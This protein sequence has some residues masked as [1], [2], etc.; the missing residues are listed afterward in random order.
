LRRLKALYMNIQELIKYKYQ[1]YLSLFIKFIK[2]KLMK[3]NTKIRLALKINYLI[4]I[5]KSIII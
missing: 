3:D 2:L 4:K 1:T 5:N